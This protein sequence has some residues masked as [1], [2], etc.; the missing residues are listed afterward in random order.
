MTMTTIVNGD[1][2]TQV[3]SVSVTQT[4]TNTDVIVTGSNL[5]A[6]GYSAL[7]YTVA[8]ATNDLDYTVYGANVSDFSDKVAIVAKNT[9]T[10]GTTETYAV[11]PPPYAYYCVYLDATVD[12]THG[13]LTVN[14]IAK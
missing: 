14:G 9:C 4:S 11:T 10:A 1:R 7:S 5:D 12:A 3:D 13:T 6:R 2:H 8:A